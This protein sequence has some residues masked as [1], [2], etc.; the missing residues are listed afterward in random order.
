MRVRLADFGMPPHPGQ[1]KFLLSRRKRVAAIAGRGWGKTEA[2]DLRAIL[3]ALENPGLS[4]AVLCPTYKQLSRNHEPRIHRYFRE[5]AANTGINLVARYHASEKRWKLVNGAEIWLLSYERYENLA[6]YDLAWACIDELTTHGAPEKVLQLLEPAVRAPGGTHH[7]VYTHTP[8]G[9]RGIVRD[10][11]ERVRAEDPDYQIICGS[12]FDNPY[13]S[14]ET[15]E[16]WKSRL[17]KALAEQE[18]YAKVL[19]PGNLV[20]D[21]FSRSRHLID[22][23]YSGGEYI[24]ACDWGDSHPAYQIWEIV[25]IDGVE[26]LICCWEYIEDGIPWEKSKQELRDVV[27][28]IGREPK[29]IVGDRAVKSMM[30]WA[31]YA[32]P[33]AIISKMETKDEQSVWEGVQVVKR[34]LDPPDDAPP[35]LLIASHLDSDRPR[36]IVNSISTLSRKTDANGEPLDQCQKDN[37]TDHS[38]DAMRMM[39]VAYERDRDRLSYTPPPIYGHRAGAR[40][41]RQFR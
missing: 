21:E 25:D 20:Y 2:L 40:A 39:V 24:L 36:G 32:F 30:Q 23:E 38:M 16:R 19:R 1:R 7:M 34:Y 29:M 11:I 31:S 35:K 6:G 15:I 5:F 18:I 13:L 33:A 8:R 22:H 26:R 10:F 14:R 17:S 27:R 12:S 41:R 28:D 37:V 4:G 3:L 9:Y